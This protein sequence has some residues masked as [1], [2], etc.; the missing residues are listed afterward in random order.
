MP[1][2][3]TI[4]DGWQVITDRLQ[5]VLQ[6]HQGG[7]WRDRSFCCTRAALL[8]CIREY[9]GDAA[10]ITQVLQFPEWHPGRVAPAEEAAALVGLPPKPVTALLPASEL[11]EAA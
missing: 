6:R 11:A 9:C 8:R 2:P 1:K 7:R 3:V 4:C 10:D 5:W